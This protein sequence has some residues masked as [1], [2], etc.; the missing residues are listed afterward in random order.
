MLWSSE[1]GAGD[2]IRDRLAPFASG[3][4]AVVPSGFDGYLR[5]L[6][7]A[8]GQGDEPG[9]TWAVVAEWAGVPL[10][11]DSSWLDIALPVH[12]RPQPLPWEGVGPE[13]GA[14]PKTVS[15]ALVDVLARHTD[16]ATGAWAATWEGFGDLDPLPDVPR[17]RLPHRDYVIRRGSVVDT[18]WLDVEGPWLGRP[19]NLWWAADRSWCVATEID[20]DHTYIGGTADL[21]DDVLRDP[22]TESQPVDV[23]TA[24]ITLR[25]PTQ[26]AVVLDQA[27]QTMLA[28]GSTTLQVSRGT[29]TANLTLPRRL[30]AGVVDVATVDDRGSTR[31]SSTS[32]V[33]SDDLGATVQQILLFAVLGL[34]T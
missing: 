6:H 25:P 20:L 17:L 2:W 27:V 18:A 22:R 29:V 26:L 4:G 8:G 5:V 34:A 21:L 12:P 11:P 7:P 16:P 28:D 1:V 31:T 23:S 30:R 3:A 19:P 15:A 24:T 33:R 32:L 9:V 14:Y 13:T 10:T